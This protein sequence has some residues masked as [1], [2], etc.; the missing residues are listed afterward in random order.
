MRCLNH[1]HTK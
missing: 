1:Y